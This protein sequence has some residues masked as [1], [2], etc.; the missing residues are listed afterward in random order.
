MLIKYRTLVLLF[1]FAIVIAGVFSK[2]WLSF[3]NTWS[4]QDFSHGMLIAPISLWLTWEL[5]D[6]IRAVPAQ[7]NLVGVIPLLLGVAIWAVGYLT[8]TTSVS[9]AGAMLVVVGGIVGIIGIKRT[10]IVWFPLFFLFLALPLLGWTSISLTNWTSEALTVLLNTTG[11]PN[12]RDGNEFVEAC[13]GLR[14]LIA[15]LVLSTLV[16]YQSFVT[17]KVSV[18]FIA[19]ALALSIV[20]N[21]FRAY[22]TVILGHITEMKFGP[23][24]EHM[25]LG[26]ILFGVIF[27]FLLKTIRHWKK[28]DAPKPNKG[29]AVL[30]C[31][32]LGGLSKL[33]VKPHVLVAFLAPLVVVPPL[34]LTQSFTVTSKLNLEMVSHQNS[35]E[36]QLVF[37]PKLVGAQA[38]VRKT[39]SHTGV[40]HLVAYFYNQPKNGA[41]LNLA[42]RVRP[43][44]EKSAWRTFGSGKKLL[45]TSSGETIPVNWLEVRN[46]NLGSY[47]IFYW[48]RIGN[49]HVLS[50]A[51]GK[52]LALKNI[53][54]G[55]GDHS[56]LNLILVP[57]ANLSTA[58]IKVELLNALDSV[59]TQ[60]DMFTD[61]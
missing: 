39:N 30:K 7:T 8:S 60:S 44:E 51:Q 37:E 14:Y 18:L 34:Y 3:Y 20:S 47:N 10:V 52:L 22:I 5:R 41:L 40:S 61:Q 38:V 29:L 57:T 31:K 35:S 26:W 28:I 42:N 53:L 17:L 46:E 43:D 24:E 2:T 11:I 6:R 12:F 27:F 23:G 4:Q 25:W 56:T 32:L 58:R 21:W 9:Q 48:Y 54:L 50:G 45:Q 59:Q 49:Y 16:A 1:G 15:T 55:K 13:S 36:R 19:F 33:N